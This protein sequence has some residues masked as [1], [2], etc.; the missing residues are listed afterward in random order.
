MVSLVEQG[1][2]NRSIARKL[3]ALRSFFNYMKKNNLV[4]KNPTIKIV[5]P[6]LAKRLPHIIQ[7]KKLEKLFDTIPSTDFED[8]QSRLIIELMYSTG[9]R[10]SELIGLTD[11][12][13]DWSNENLK[14]LGKGNKERIL[15]LSPVMI[16]KLKDF[17]NFRDAHFAEAKKENYL[18]LTQKGLKIYPKYLYNL[19]R[20]YLSS[21]SMMEKRSPHVLRHSFATHLMD[22]GADLNAVKK[23]LGHANLAATQVYTHNSVE[24]LKEI[25]RKAHPKST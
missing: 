8:V 6:K 25:Y 21:V 9:I 19:V 22:G 12:A 4:L 7:E 13:I 11:C 17:I 10:R 16:S 5:T 1:I 2:G 14:V 18:F 15:P 23:L 24:K 3:S 20:K